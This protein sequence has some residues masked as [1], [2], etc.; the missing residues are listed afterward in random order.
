M[1]DY[2]TALGASNI[3]VNGVTEAVFM[4]QAAWTYPA[5]FTLGATYKFGGMIDTDNSDNLTSGDYILK[6][7]KYLTVTG[8]MIVEVEYPTM[9]I[10]QP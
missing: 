4:G 2:S 8:N 7:M 5:L 3:I 10:L 6:E 9:F 1:T